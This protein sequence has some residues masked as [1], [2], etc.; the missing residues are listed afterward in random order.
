ME[1]VTVDKVDAVV[2]D[3]YFEKESSSK[4]SWKFCNQTTL[5]RSEVVF[6][7]QMFVI[8]LLIS[9][10]IVKLTVLKPN[11]E[12]TSVWIFILSSLFGYILP[13]PRLRIKL[14]LRKIESSV[15]PSCCRALRFR[16]RAL[17]LWQNGVNFQNVE[18]K[19]ILPKIEPH[20]FFI[21]R[22]ATNI[23]QNGAETCSYFQK[24]CQF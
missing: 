24:V 7:V 23:H 3:N 15:G 14:Y 10:C 16:C 9:L 22:N 18:W 8:L 6:F 17:R 13:N 21:P 2:E 19:H 4:S 1:G 12:E 11:C 20:Y 5:P